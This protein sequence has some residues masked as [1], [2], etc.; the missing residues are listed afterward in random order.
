M[1]RFTELAEIVRKFRRRPFIYTEAMYSN[2]CWLPILNSLFSDE[3]VYIQAEQ[4]LNVIELEYPELR[5]DYTINLNCDLTISLLFCELSRDYI[6][7]EFLSHKDE[8]KIAN[9]MGTSLLKLFGLFW[10]QGR[11]FLERLAIY[12]ILGAGTD[13]DVAVLYPVFPNPENDEEFYFAFQ[14]SK[15]YLRYKILEKDLRPRN[16]YLCSGSEK[17]IHHHSNAT[18]T[19]TPEAVFLG[20]NSSN[21][22]DIN[23]GFCEFLFKEG[24]LNQNSLQVL[25]RVAELVYAQAELING[26]LGN[27]NIPSQPDPRFKYDSEQVKL[28]IEGR[29]SHAHS[30]PKKAKRVKVDA[31]RGVNRFTVFQLMSILTAYIDEKENENE[32]LKQN[33][34]NGSYKEKQD[35]IPV[36][37]VIKLMS[38]YEVLVY[39]AMEGSVHVPRMFS[40]EFQIDED[41]DHVV[42]LELER[43]LPLSKFYCEFHDKGPDFMTRILFDVIGGLRTLHSKGYVHGDVTPGN[44]G[45]NPIRNIWNLFDFDS[46]RPIENAAAGD[47]Y[48]YK[49]TDGFTSKNY[50]TS[51]F[52]KYYVFDDYVGLALTCES[53]MEKMSNLSRDLD[54]MVKLDEFLHL[55]IDCEDS[56]VKSEQIDFLYLEAFKLHLEYSKTPD[57]PSI[58]A[59]VPLLQE[60][61]AKYNL[62]KLLNIL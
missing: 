34:N 32:A 62:K 6:Q 49:C 25:E 26:V 8:D 57:D 7:S 41:G 59:A 29:P 35:F 50:E 28:M 27:Q 51:G 16:L 4:L 44:I 5:T 10:S 58:N 30:S 36:M 18:P 39:K 56:K 38:K 11:Q 3:A 54:F 37:N 14:A 42:K 52:T 9:S 60:M 47:E 53:V 48:E 55:I 21:K 2:F 23:S 45:F 13:F 17:T 24:V 1:L 22:N 20:P 61:K 31:G 43:L 40:H 46:S 12:G 15:K 19:T 33:L